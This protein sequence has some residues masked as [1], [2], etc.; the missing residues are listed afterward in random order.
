MTDSIGDGRIKVLFIVSR[1]NIGGPAFHVMDLTTGLDNARFAPQ[2]VTGLE[3]AREGSL[4]EHARSLGVETVTISQMRGEASLRPR[5]VKGLAALWRLMRQERPHIVHTH[6]GKAGLL[7]RLAAYLA[8][9]PIVVHTFHG[10]VLYGYFGPVKNWL[11]RRMESTLTRITDQIVA[12]SDQISQDLQS[13]GVA[14][15]EKIALIPLGFDLEPFLSSAAHEGR[16]REE[17]GLDPSTK[18]VGIVGRLVPIKNH[19]LFLDAAARVVA[20]VPASYFAVV[21]DGESRLEIESYARELGISDRVKFTGWRH[22]LPTVYADLDVLTL[23]SDNEGTPMSVIEGM[24]SGCPIVATQVGGLVDLVADQETGY[25]VPPNEPE[26]LASGILRVLRDPHAAGRMTRVARA[27][28]AERFG[29]ER[30][31]ADISKLYEA[32]LTEKGLSPQP[33]SVN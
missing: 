15:P 11:L 9:V 4:V 17:L 10:H 23:S 27:Q 33:E 3:T 21:G 19:R 2:L 1:M 30:L 7:G 26:A 6:A 31:I 13:Y 12:I 29:R 18:L 24:A 22:D 32:I 16:F 8:G 28:V 25:L 14:T 20:E 5:D